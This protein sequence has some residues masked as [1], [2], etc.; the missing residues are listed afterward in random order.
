MV[1]QPSRAGSSE[2]AVSLILPVV[3]GGGGLTSDELWRELRLVLN[4]DFNGSQA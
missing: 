2:Q 1:G 4:S 3:E